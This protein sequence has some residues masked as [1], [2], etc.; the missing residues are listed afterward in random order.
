[1]F[2]PGTDI[3]VEDAMKQ[4]QKNLIQQGYSP[5]EARKQA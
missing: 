3:K 2:V 4:T 5:E 1:M